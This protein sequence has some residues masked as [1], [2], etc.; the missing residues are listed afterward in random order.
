MS[1]TYLAFDLGAESGRA[2]LGHLD[3]SRLTLTE[4]HRFPNHPVTHNGSLRW[5]IRALYSEM[6][7]ALD[8][9]PP[10]LTGVGVD[11]WGIDF[12]LLDRRGE[13]LE[14]P[15]HY[16]DR[17]TEGVIDSVCAKIPRE[18]I[19]SITGVQ[20]LPINT[21][22]QLCAMPPDG[23]VRA[24]TF[25]TIPDLLNF[26]LT[27]RKLNEYTNATTTQLLDAR[28]RDWAWDL[29]AELGLP[30]RIFQPIL[31][32]GTPIGQLENGSPVIAPACHDTGSAV[33]ALAMTPES[34][35]ISSGTWS[36]LGAER[37]EPIL[38]PLARDCNFTNEGGVCG[39]IRVLKN[40]T[41]LWLLQAC[42]RSWSEDGRDFS[43]DELL[44]AA[45]AE[46]GGRS[47]VD[48]DDPA[49]LN[50]PSMPR[51]IGAYCES[52]GRPAPQSPPAVTRAILESLALKY[53][54]VIESLEGI[55][56]ARYAEIRVVGGGSRNRLLNQLTANATGRTVVAGP[57]EA[58]ALGNI[59]MQMLAT[60]TVS[61]LAEARAI[62][63]QS[64][65]VDRFAPREH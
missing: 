27:G 56:G 32:P 49:F 16:R 29:I 1:H 35:F 22:Y 61:S 11:T 60:D 26:W 34:V 62:I 40:I 43:Y 48:P 21:L 19:Y 13:L 9:A 25:L 8:L 46:P 37:T 23:F 20:F 65:P 51:A 57:V 18:R 50:P 59:A 3:A 63:E 5:N 53:A 55:T 52:I 12:A 31:Q 30:S 7:R 15:Y 24:E 58:T 45:T 6:R 33:A 64:F 41:G 54:H 42:R 44:A 14:D 28:T 38:T 4:L 2:M 39:T 10:N 47:I 17:R 36:L